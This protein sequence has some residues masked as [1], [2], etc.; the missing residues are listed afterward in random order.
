[1]GRF[2]RHSLKLVNQSFQLQLQNKFRSITMEHIYLT[3]AT[4][5]QTNILYD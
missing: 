5:C 4:F 2:F 1:M 3:K